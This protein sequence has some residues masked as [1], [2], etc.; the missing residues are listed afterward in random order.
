MI[1]INSVEF[2]N[3][4]IIVKMSD[5]QVIETPINYYPNLRKGTQNQISNYEI[6]GG[7]RWIHWEELDEDLSA[8]GF[9]SMQEKQN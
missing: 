8:E 2:S 6:K 7:G 3:E 5:G 9:L 4:N 1:T